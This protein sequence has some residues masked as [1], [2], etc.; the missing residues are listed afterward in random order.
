MAVDSLYLVAW[1]DRALLPLDPVP[2]NA[3][4]LIT[5]WQAGLDPLALVRDFAR[6]LLVA[7][8][9]AA[10]LADWVLTDRVVEVDAVR[11]DLLLTLAADPEIAAALEAS[12]GYL[13]NP[14]VEQ[15]G[16]DLAYIPAYFHR[17]A[18]SRLV[19]AAP[20]EDG[21]LVATAA[22]PILLGVAIIWTLEPGVTYH[23]E[24]AFLSD[25]ANRVMRRQKS[26]ELTET[27]E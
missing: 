24:Q 26:D 17:L 18:I 14:H 5:D 6:Q 3:T 15:V 10:E 8:S 2:L 7:D 12:V 9:R 23:A 19:N 16:R 1:P 22:I 20:A 21:R 27:A 4:V 11:R 13:R 25:L